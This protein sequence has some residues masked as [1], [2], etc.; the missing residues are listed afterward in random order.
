M[1]NPYEEWGAH[2]EELRVPKT[3]AWVFSI[4]FIALISLPPVLRNGHEALREL[5]NKDDSR[6]TPVVEFFK[7]PN[8]KAL[9]ALAGKK[10][11][12]PDITREHPNLRDHL[13]AVEAEIDQAPYAKIIRQRTQAK[14]TNWF[15]E[16]NTKTLLGDRE[17]IYLRAGID[18]LTGYGPLKPEPDSVMKDPDR[19]NWTAPLPVIEKFAAQLKER[20]IELLLVP[21]PVK[22]MIYPENIGNGNWDGPVHHRDQDALYDKL[23]QAGID[24]L[25]LSDTFW[26]LK[27]Q[28]P[29]FLNQ[30]THWTQNT[31]QKAAEEVAAKIK[32]RPWFNSVQAGLQTKQ[33]S[34]ERNHIGDLVEMLDLVNP[35]T[36]FQPEVQSLKIVNDSSTDKR[37][38]ND[39]TSPLVLLGDS[40]VNIYDDPGI[41]FGIPNWK[42]EEKPAGEQADSQP[43][44]GAGFAQH[45]AAQLET[46]LDLITANGGGATQVRKEFAQRADNEVR[47]KKL[48][49]WVIASRDL[50]L[51]ETPSLPAK[52]R[53]SDV[54]FNKRISTTPTHPVVD[55]ANAVIIETELKERTALQDPKSTPYKE[56]VYSAIFIVSKKVKGDFKIEGDEVPAYLWGFRDRKVLASGRLEVGKKYRLTLVPWASKTKLQ[57]VQKMDDLLV[58]SDWWFVEKV[59]EIQE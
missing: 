9:A 32:S 29:V 52:V 39:K 34:A 7:H 14:L 51:S 11:N 3:W 40:F 33:T 19:P 10:Q 38:G 55:S 2:P 26:S 31:M 41:G 53:W 47:A 35:K 8:P 6:W 44:I 17:R 21:V 36:L 25:D 27:E 58:F 23:R 46:P 5:E 18:G 20:G 15:G 22:A 4:V 24:V 45:L 16:G 56:A 37:V 48:V 59:E 42:S 1:K 49:V 57:T 43:L 30:D 13:R 28:G 50:L 54:E 12:N